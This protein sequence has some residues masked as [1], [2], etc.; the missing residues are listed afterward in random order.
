MVSGLKSLDFGLLNASLWALGHHE[1]HF[2]R[3][4][5]LI[6]RDNNWQINQ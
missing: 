6:N 1:E 3:K 5:E 2:P 4:N